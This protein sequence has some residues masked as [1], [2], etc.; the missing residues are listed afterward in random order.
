MTRQE[1]SCSPPSNT[2]YL[3]RPEKEVEEKVKKIWTFGWKKAL[4]YSG[5]IFA[6]FRFQHKEPL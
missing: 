1:K 5:I 3:A 2:K 4:V 6:N